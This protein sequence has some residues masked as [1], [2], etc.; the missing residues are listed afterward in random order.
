MDSQRF[1]VPKPRRAPQHNNPSPSLDRL[2]PEFP[3]GPPASPEHIEQGV[4]A[5]LADA[6]RGN[7]AALHARLDFMRE[8][9]LAAQG[10][11][12]EY[13]PDTTTDVV[14]RVPNPQFRHQA[15]QHH[16]YSPLQALAPAISHRAAEFGPRLTYGPNV[17]PPTYVD[18]DVALRRLHK[19]PDWTGLSQLDIRM[20]RDIPF[21]RIHRAVDGESVLALILGYA[22]RTVD[23]VTKHHYGYPRNRIAV[24]ARA[25]VHDERTSHGV[26]RHAP[27]TYFLLRREVKLRLNLHLRP[28]ATVRISERYLHDN[29]VPF[30]VLTS[31]PLFPPALAPP[32]QPWAPRPQIP[33]QAPDN[34]YTHCQISFVSA[35]SS[36]TSRCQEPNPSL[37][38]R[39]NIKTARCAVPKC[40]D[41]IELR[42]CP[43]PDIH[44]DVPH[45]F[46]P[47]C[48]FR[49]K[50]G[51]P[52]I[53]SSPS[54][55]LVL[56]VPYL[57]DARAAPSFLVLRPISSSASSIQIPPTL[58]FT[59][60]TWRL[61]QMPLIPSTLTDAITTL[62]STD[63]L[64]P[65]SSSSSSTTPTLNKLLIALPPRRPERTLFLRAWHT[66]AQNP[67]AQSPLPT[68]LTPSILHLANFTTALY[69]HFSFLANIVPGYVP[70]LVISPAADRAV[71]SVS[72]SSSSSS[73]F[74]HFPTDSHFPPE[75]T[76][77]T[78]TTTTTT[79]E[80]GDET[81]HPI[82][83]LLSPLTSQ[84]DPHGLR[85]A[86]PGT[87]S[88][89]TPQTSPLTNP[90]N[91]SAH[92]ARTLTAR[93][94]GS[95]QPSRHC[96]RVVVV[97]RR[98]TN[99]NNR[100][101]GNG[102]NGNGNGNNGNGKGS[103]RAVYEEEEEVLPT[104]AELA[105]YPR[106]RWNV[107]LG[108]RQEWRGLRGVWVEEVQESTSTSTSPAE[109]QA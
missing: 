44:N 5:T 39:H 97:V 79:D 6:S 80:E 13:A 27:G 103:E 51:A 28:T 70:G 2:T 8:R 61:S 86:G 33:P 21:E 105:M 50:H 52:P 89:L 60:H 107:Y 100:A 42:F 65:P 45:S 7:V 49:S 25:T 71:G 54:Q 77:T 56:S 29:D 46:N 24:A 37:D 53:S 1:Y 30:A 81:P 55:T 41:T 87:T 32:F 15:V 48:Y 10:I 16:H 92:L 76:T 78:T 23:V 22:A 84:R 31:N 93:V 102:G 20:L 38:T 91:D 99:T 57:A 98:H 11:Q 95:F 63:P 40:I 12:P 75:S 74:S 90:L 58:A 73:F 101:N 14:N 66:A 85:I 72:A 96:S 9:N 36:C 35:S 108:E 68:F 83:P 17:P 69:T 43:K 18:R 104:A 59:L 94:P 88:T 67:T 109:A 64:S 26:F 106:P 62:T 3:I 4:Y 19:P 47:I 82:L 34:K